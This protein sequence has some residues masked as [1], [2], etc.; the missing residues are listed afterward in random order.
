M[1]IFKTSE[2]KKK[3]IEIENKIHMIFSSVKYDN[4]RRKASNEINEV[5]LNCQFSD[6]LR[7]FL[8]NLESAW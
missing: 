6:I 8:I 3:E 1:K 4:I 2:R 7:K 5:V